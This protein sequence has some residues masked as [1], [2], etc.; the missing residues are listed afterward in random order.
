[1]RVILTI[2]MSLLTLIALTGCSLSSQDQFVGSAIDQ[3][4][5]VPKEAIKTEHKSNNPNLIYVAYELKGLN[6]EEGI[7]DYYHREI[8]KWGWTE[9]NEA[10][11]GA[12]YVFEKNNK[13]IHMTIHNGFFTLS[14]EYYE[15]GYLLPLSKRV[16]IL[17][18]DPRN[19][20]SFSFGIPLLI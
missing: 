20:T 9:K 11:L 5:P 6:F 13:T 18:E 3:D 16:H 7:P 19:L 2:F 17:K 10:Q 1:M 14:I 4:F 8:E 12:L 15:Y